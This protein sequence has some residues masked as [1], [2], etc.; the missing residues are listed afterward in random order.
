ME[1][2]RRTVIRR[3]A[4][5]ALLALIPV[6]LL[7]GQSSAADGVGRWVTNR[8]GGD[9]DDEFYVHFTRP[10]VG[11]H[12]KRG[13]GRLLAF[14]KRNRTTGAWHSRIERRVAQ[15][16]SG[17]LALRDLVS[18]AR[19]GEWHLDDSEYAARYGWLVGA[20][21]DKYEGVL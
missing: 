12:S 5:G 18:R 3:G 11:R 17:S 8:F 1:M 16:E 15:G 2:T 10:D 19:Q 7:G 13:S 4:F 9:P 21:T 14:S 6:R 20:W